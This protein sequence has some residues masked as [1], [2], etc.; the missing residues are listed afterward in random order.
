V[1]SGRVGHGLAISVLMACHNRADQTLRCLS[2]LKGQN[3]LH[4]I[5]V[6]VILVDDGS[7]DGTSERVAADFPEVQ[8]LRGDGTL[9]WNRAMHTACGV[10]LAS[11]C[12]FVLW[13]NDDTVLYPDALKTLLLAHESL[14]SHISQPLIVVGTLC[15]RDKH[16][17]SYGGWRTTNRLNPADCR[18]I[19]PADKAVE[20]DTMNGNCVLISHRALLATG[21]LD[22]VFT[23]SMGDLD[24]GFRAR[25]AG[26]RI[27]VAPGFVGECRVN[28]GKGLWTDQSLPW[29]ERVWRMLGPKGL[30]PSQWLAFTRRH[31]GPFWLL[32]WMNPYIKML[33][34]GLCASVA[35]TRNGS[36]RR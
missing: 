3:A 14:A 36:G 35:R 16:C 33:W 13:L 25:R 12:D 28:E 2:A 21:N 5:T 31:S 17:V 23:H 29:L 15:D 26:C 8:I 18:R 19:A 30:P 1:N 6:K 22:P 10:A 4:G 34:A 9:F 24:Y 20:C 7:S 11:S 32:F 27:W